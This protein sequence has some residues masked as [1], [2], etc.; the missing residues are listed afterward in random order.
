MTYILAL[1]LSLNGQEM[2]VAIS[3]QNLTPCV[4]SANS[5]PERIVIVNGVTANVVHAECYKVGE[6]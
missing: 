2:T 4:I 5:M 1:V 3:Y 6:Q